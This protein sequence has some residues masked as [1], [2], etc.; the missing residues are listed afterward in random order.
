M[1]VVRQATRNL[2]PAAILLLASVL[3]MSTAVLAQEEEP[4]FFGRLFGTSKEAP[5]P[6]ADAGNIA[7]KAE[8][9]PELYNA[10]YGTCVPVS[11]SQKLSIDSTVTIRFAEP[12]K[13]TG[14]AVYVRRMSDE[15]DVSGEFLGE[16]FFRLSSLGKVTQL[17]TNAT[18][19][20][21]L[22]S[23]RTTS[24]LKFEITEITGADANVC[25]TELE[26]YGSVEEGEVKPGLNTGL[27]GNWVVEYSDAGKKEGTGVTY[28]YGE[29]GNTLYSA[30]SLW[31][32]ENTATTGI[33]NYISCNVPAT[34]R[35]SD[36]QFTVSPEGKI[37]HQ[38]SYGFMGHWGGYSTVKQVGP[39]EIRGRWNYQDQYGGLE[40]WRRVRPEITRVT[41]GSD[42]FNPRQRPGHIEMTYDG[43]W[44]GPTVD[45]RA[46]RPSFSIHVYGNNLWGRKN[47]RIEPRLDSANYV[48]SDLEVRCCGGVHGP[49]SEVV[50]LGMEV[51]AWAGVVPG[52]KTLYVDDIAIPFDFVIHGHPQENEA[53]WPDDANTL[54]LMLTVIGEGPDGA[55][56]LAKL[57]EDKPFQIKVSYY[58]VPDNAPT[59]ATVRWP[60]GSKEVALSPT[61]DPKTFTS[62]WHYLA[63]A[64]LRDFREVPGVQAATGHSPEI[65]AD[66]FAGQWDVSHSGSEGDDARGVA[67]MSEDGK[68]VRLLLVNENK[69]SRYESFDVLATRD[70]S[71]GR[72]TLDVRFER[73]KD[74]E[75]WGP[76]KTR[77]P[78][79]IEPMAALGSSMIQP[80]GSS[81]RLIPD[82]PDAP[83]ANA[84]DVTSTEISRSSEGTER[85]IPD[86]PDAP[87]DNARDVTST[88]I[89]RSSEGTE[90]LIP[91]LPDTPI[92]EGDVPALPDEAPALDNRVI[93]VADT[94]EAITVAAEGQ[95][96][97]LAVE[98]PDGPPER[99]RVSLMRRESGI[100]MSGA[101]SRELPDGT[102]G[103][104][105]Q[106]TWGTATRIEKVVVLENQ[107]PI[108]RELGSYDDFMKDPSPRS[109][110]YIRAPP[111]SNADNAT[112]Y[113]FQEGAQNDSTRRRL[114][115]VGQNLPQRPAD[116]LN[117][118][119]GN[120]RFHYSLFALP[121]EGYDKLFEMGWRKA[122]IK[123]NAK[124]SALVVEARFE[125]GTKPGVKTLSLNGAPGFWH[126]DFADANA[127]MEFSHRWQE[128]IDTGAGEYSLA[129]TAY[130]DDLIY[131]TLT[132]QAPL[133]FE[134]LGIDLFKND[135]EV[136]SLYA[137]RYEPP[138][139]GEI[140]RQW[141]EREQQKR[142]GSVGSIRD[143][144]LWCKRSRGLP[145][146]R[147]E[148]I[149]LRPV[150]PLL[151]EGGD[152]TAFLSPLLDVPVELDVN[153][154]DV[155][156]ARISKAYR[157]RMQAIPGTARTTLISHPGDLGPTWR[158][159]LKRAAACYEDGSKDIDFDTI[160]REEAETYSKF[161]FTENIL[162]LIMPLWP[163][164]VSFRDIGI[165]KGDHAAA[166]LIRDEFLKVTEPQLRELLE[167]ATDNDKLWQFYQTRVSSTMPFW[168]VMK[169]KGPNDGWESETTAFL[170]EM[171]YQVSVESMSPL[172]KALIDAAAEY[173]PQ[174]Q[175]DGDWPIGDL[176]YA[177]TTNP[178]GSGISER[179][180]HLYAV[181]KTKQALMEL[182]NRA[183]DAYARATKAG[184]CNVEEL[185]LIGGQDAGDIV[186]RILPRL[187]QAS[188]DGPGAYWQPDRVAQAYV[189][190][191]K[192][193]GAAIRALE[194]YGRIDEAYQAL[195]LAAVTAGAAATLTAG[196]LAASGAALMLVADAADMIYFGSKALDQYLESEPLIA[197][198]QGATVGGLGEEFY[199]EAEAMRTEGWEAA[200]A[201]LA[202]A[203]GVVSG[204]GSVRAIRSVERGS[205]VLKG[206]KVLDADAIGRLSRVDQDA[207]LSY[208]SDLHARRPGNKLRDL[209]NYGRA[210]RDTELN[211][212]KKF[213][214]FYRQGGLDVTGERMRHIGTPAKIADE[215]EET[216][217]L[218]SSGTEATGIGAENVRRAGDDAEA[219]RLLADADTVRFGNEADDAP[220][221]ITGR[222]ATA[223]TARVGDDT[224]RADADAL[225]TGDNTPVR[226]ARNDPDATADTVR[227][228][229]DTL[230]ADAD[231]LRTGDNAPVR[232]ASNDPNAAPAR[233]TGDAADPN[234]PYVGLDER[235]GPFYRDALDDDA[236][237]P[238]SRSVD[239]T[240]RTQVFPEA[241]RATTA[242][243]KTDLD[244][245]G[246]V[247]VV[248]RDGAQRNINIGELRGKGATA[249][250]Y[251]IGGEEGS[252][253]WRI[254]DAGSTF[255]AVN[256]DV[257]RAKMKNVLDQNPDVDFVRLADQK[258]QIR[259]ASSSDARLNG[260]IIERVEA[261]AS[262]AHA[263]IAAQGGIP[264]EGQL[265]AMDQAKR[266]FNREGLVWTD[267]HFKN[268]D[269]VPMQVPGRPDVHQVVI[270]D[271]GHVYPVSGGTPFQKWQNARKFQKEFA[272][273]P[274]E[275]VTSL[276]GE[277][278]T[279]SHR[280]LRRNRL[281]DIHNDYK[282]LINREELPP[283]MSEE[284][285]FGGA[286]HTGAERPFYREI[287]AMDADAADRRFFEHTGKRPPP[288]PEPDGADLAR[289]MEPIRISMRPPTDPPAT[290]TPVAGSSRVPD[291]EETLTIDVADSNVGRN[292]D[293]EVTLDVDDVN[294]GAGRN[295]DDEATLDVDAADTN[296]GRNASGDTTRFDNSDL[297]ALGNDTL[298]LDD[299][300]L[301]GP[302]APASDDLR[303][304][305]TPDGAMV[306]DETMLGQGK[307]ADVH[308]LLGPDGA[309]SGSVIKRYDVNTGNGDSH[310]FP[311][312]Q[313]RVRASEEGS[314]QL[315]SADVLQA[316][317]RHV[318]AQNGTI[319][320]R[321][322]N[323]DLPAGVTRETVVED[324]VRERG[325]GPLGEVE[326]EGVARMFKKL[327][328]NE[329]AIEDPNSGNIFLREMS[330]S[331]TPV[332]AG[333]LDQ[334]RI[335]SK[336]EFGILD[337]V[338]TDTPKPTNGII[339]KSEA[340]ELGL[341][342]D[343]GLWQETT[344]MGQPV[345]E[346]RTNIGDFKNVRADRE[347]SYFRTLR[348]EG[349]SNAEI[350]E[351][352]TDGLLATPK[353]FN[354]YTMIEKGWLKYEPGVGFSSGM[355][356]IKAAA[357]E[358]P[359]LP[360][361][362]HLTPGAEWQNAVPTS[363]VDPNGAAPTQHEYGYDELPLAA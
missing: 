156:E 128:D 249:A 295:F 293:D 22:S 89:S 58:S 272:V 119:A 258:E 345:Y 318:D 93:Y 253:L 139:E 83:L 81:T 197:Y 164:N 25:L 111:P 36:G 313:G 310:L 306:T 108:A 35:C 276:V 243:W 32:N 202:P 87:L 124:F 11:G 151:I 218:A 339:N 101:W 308:R 44:W 344:Y 92:G 352:S 106:Q 271:T 59:F 288:P 136:A 234:G 116:A 198:A 28:G 140:H 229:D 323:A 29:K 354:Y 153:K 62:L 105:G 55:I 118:K 46:N 192:E 311:Q 49:S 64:S 138:G 107:R 215:L 302:W 230:R 146:Y 13:I 72:H 65:A 187:V 329:I 315:Q 104:G 279:R 251:G 254:R 244:G 102:L 100:Q 82:L 259:V 274:D 291:G 277:T 321:E 178:A 71:G 199:Y 190:S 117:L 76:L 80:A 112:E 125:D 122:R 16:G 275:F 69:R 137:R 312:Q 165:R 226:T 309:P 267:G 264:T 222:D 349:K 154:G 358:F 255:S 269:L 135:I 103:A 205:E 322:V 113:P 342:L 189:R 96:K 278:N 228:S 219:D 203:V 285:H 60:D 360:E 325:A 300:D 37:G 356:D 240:D 227:A 43:Y 149:R 237:T 268:F 78:G 24:N 351:L 206:I 317:L 225:R 23:P 162:Q 141:C 142:G 191:L 132:E 157:D 114:F 283:G 247:T 194:S 179:H 332:R 320:Q 211:D 73:K 303:N 42:E 109:A 201:L 7:W 171:G 324:I 169:V 284:H 326:S 301:P 235:L 186:A 4:G 143:F 232:T 174:G 287:A 263:R 27:E 74:G 185:M 296:V 160:T 337:H 348:R 305:E 286:P 155:L 336:E 84:R 159:A 133:E 115:I 362:L 31:P 350:L 281:N 256:D 66:L 86:L 236:A 39:D 330:G 20:I 239:S 150:G 48:N 45:Q 294:A 340:D 180:A 145:D 175:S 38:H 334:D 129:E 85:L 297:D 134:G 172:A 260:K 12:V 331:D 3:F 2:N 163:G 57:D 63:P 231:T 195:A 233:T 181:R 208:F 280:R 168:R 241:P 70:S 17:G 68:N 52:R 328:E 152:Q 357:K 248:G 54:G 167:I 120:E 200:V 53:V 67:L 214:D 6:R 341:D 196:G 224:L 147:S 90:R 34:R 265:V 183:A 299:P 213:A 355:M 98:L 123:D 221:T 363:R 193:K 327:N 361:V 14:A 212:F 26:V 40:V 158:N 209:N 9:P 95:A 223:D 88:E 333:V 304:W 262:T 130:T 131:V 144:K 220:T 94:T 252:D 347:T 41:V 292:F 182:V 30:Y 270:F 99:I 126:L 166:I 316:E 338:D 261:V 121:G 289:E 8:M 343:S 238:A 217:R 257:G 77:R 10:D 127:F 1:F 173:L 110:D 5:A 207:L 282:G 177:I 298:R 15:G 91:D 33:W 176:V 242:D 346:S 51:L 266:L 56:D 335:I 148:P 21:S 19:R 50:G 210:L 204:V 61:D 188:G 47:I 79:S 216:R 18:A 307:F 290:N 170:T 353:A 319:I 273:P 184:D 314:K 75:S 245:A 246:E 359:D 97:E 161:V 250:V